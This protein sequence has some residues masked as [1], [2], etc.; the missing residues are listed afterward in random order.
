[1]GLNFE[2]KGNTFKTSFGGF[3]TLIFYVIIVAASA[4]AFSNV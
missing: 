3:L 2:K 1:V 4:L